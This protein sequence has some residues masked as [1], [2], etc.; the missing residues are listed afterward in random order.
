M[1]LKTIKELIKSKDSDLS[2]Q[3]YELLESYYSDSKMLVSDIQESYGISKK[4][5]ANVNVLNDVFDDLGFSFMISGFMAKLNRRV[6]SSIQKIYLKNCEFPH[7]LPRYFDYLTHI[8]LVNL[9]YCHL[10]RFNDDHNPF[11]QA[12]FNKKMLRTLR[13][14]G[15]FSYDLHHYI[16]I[17]HQLEE[18]KLT[19]CGLTSI[20]DYL[21]DFKALRRLDLSNNKLQSL[22]FNHVLPS[23]EEFSCSYNSL[24]EVSASIFKQKSLTKLTLSRNKIRG[25]PSEIDHLK[26]LEELNISSNF[27]MT[28]PNS[29]SRLKKLKKIRVSS[30]LMRGATQALK[31][32]P[33][34]VYGDI[35]PRFLT[36]TP[37]FLMKWSD[38]YPVIKQLYPSVSSY[39]KHYGNRYASTRRPLSS[40]RPYLLLN[41]HNFGQDLSL[42]LR[43]KL[44][45]YFRMIDPNVSAEITYLDL[46][47]QEIKQLPAEIGFLEELQEL[48]LCNN[49]LKVLPEELSKLTQLTYLNVNRNQLGKLPKDLSR[50]TLLETLEVKDNRLKSI[51]SQIGKLTSLRVLDLSEN[52]LTSSGSYWKSLPQLEVLNLSYNQLRALNPALKGSSVRTLHLSYNRLPSD[53]LKAKALFEIL[54]EMEHLRVIVLK[55]V[56]WSRLSSYVK[57]LTQIEELY[58]DY[59]R[60]KTLPKLISE[61]TNIKVISLYFNGL[62]E[63]PEDFTGEIRS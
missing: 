55:N 11:L 31:R 19:R 58:L 3:G 42:D 33:A 5:T 27:L 43:C 22:D 26:N 50:W 48:V 10:N 25:L 56:S 35:S 45:V 4:I 53:R 34:Q 18:L 52:R 6:A 14:N 63:E 62:R 29:L 21:S 57:L 16:K 44:L 49:E 1:F 8:K 54:S 59:N 46:S 37:N 13:I 36:D 28:L 23:L 32:F 12:L 61:L 24:T 9:S 51:P 38:F 7:Y 47:D 15:R 40:Y 30:N 39:F 17:L 2:E 41:L 20:P 60:I